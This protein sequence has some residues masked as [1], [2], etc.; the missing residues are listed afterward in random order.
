ML[1][2]ILPAFAAIAMFCG[3]SSVQ[4]QYLQQGYHQGQ[5]Y[6]QGYRQPHHHQNYGSPHH[7][8]YGNPYRQSNYQ[9][10]VTPWCGTQAPT[11]SNYYGS[12]SGYYGQSQYAAPYQ[13]NYPNWQPSNYY[14]RGY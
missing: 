3:S 4:A 7:G 11:N 12:Q 6:G 5:G 13:S 9:T 14:P 8:G 10:P 1:K 2:L